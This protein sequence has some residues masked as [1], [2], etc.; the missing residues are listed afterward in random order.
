MKHPTVRLEADEG[1]HGHAE[2][3]LG[4]YEVANLATAAIVGALLT[5]DHNQT[6]MEVLHRH[7]P[8]GQLKPLYFRCSTSL[9]LIHRPTAPFATLHSQVERGSMCAGSLGCSWSRTAFSTW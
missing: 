4:W 6:V 9:T 7:H 8:H 3:F 5:R 2:T 1:R